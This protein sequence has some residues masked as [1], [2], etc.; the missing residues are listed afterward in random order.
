VRVRHDRVVAVLGLVLI[1]IGLLGLVPG[2]ELGLTVGHDLAHLVPGLALAWAG[3]GSVSAR[4]RRVLTLSV[5]AVYLGIGLLSVAVPG[6]VDAILG[7]PASAN[8][9]HLL[10]AAG[11]GVVGLELGP[12]VQPD[13]RH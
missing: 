4:S 5:G 12:V 11:L 10:L 6:R 2:I 1:A 8:L 7:I 3:W 9:L 13:R